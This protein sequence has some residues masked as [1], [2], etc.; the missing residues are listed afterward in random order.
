MQLVKRLIMPKPNA[1]EEEE[2]WQMGRD[3]DLDKMTCEWGEDVSYVEKIVMRM[4]V[5]NKKN[6]FTN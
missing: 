1:E 6:S 5:I 2:S 4:K 3:D